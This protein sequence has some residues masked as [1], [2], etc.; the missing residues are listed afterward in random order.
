MTR[1]RA[2]L[3]EECRMKVVQVPI[4]RVI[5]YERNPRRNEGA[6]S[7]VEASLREFGWRQPIVVDCEMV[8]VAGHT[9]LLAA[10]RLGLAKV[11]VHVANDLTPEQAAG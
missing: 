2:D 10:R 9:R 1:K 3:G 6:V 7:K 11:P 4:E 8:V 5:P